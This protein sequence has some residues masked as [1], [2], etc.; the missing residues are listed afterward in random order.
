MQPGGVGAVLSQ[1]AAPGCGRWGKWW[2]YDG[3]GL[4]WGM[5][6][7]GTHSLDMVQAALGTD[8]TG[9][10][11]VWPRRPGHE[12]S[13]VTMRYPDGTLLELTLPRGYGSFWGAKYIGEKGTIERNEGRRQRP[14]GPGCRTSQV[15]RLSDRTASTELDRLHAQPAAPACRCG[16]RPPFVNSLSPGQHCPRAGPPDCSG[17]PTGKSSWP[18]PRPTPCA[19]GRGAG[20]TSCREV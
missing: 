7:W 19:R 17:A 16:D 1:R 6:G 18:T 11:E 14:A 9:P 12:K 3:G 13:P 2:A 20:A 10:V 15:R 5:T 8:Y 4:S